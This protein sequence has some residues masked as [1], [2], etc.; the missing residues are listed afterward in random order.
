MA[1]RAETILAAYP[2]GLPASTKTYGQA[3]DALAA[4]IEGWGLEVLRR[5]PI[6]GR[7]S[8]DI[9]VSSKSVAVE[10]CGLHWHNEASPTPR[11]K[12]YHWNKMR[13]AA[14]RGLR[15]ITIFEDEWRERRPQVTG[16]LRSILGAPHARVQARKCEV[17]ELDAKTARVF[18]EDHHIQRLNTSQL[19][20]WGLTETCTGTLV[21]VV[22]LRHHR[23]S[24]DRSKVDL[25]RLCFQTDYQVVGGA[26]RLI[27]HAA[28]WAKSAGYASIVTWSDNRWFTGAVYERLGFNLVRDGGPDYAYVKVDCSRGRIPKE[29]FRKSRTG[30]PPD[31]LEHVRA[32]EEG[33][34]RIW[35]CG[36]KRWELQL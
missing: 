33:Y 28:A 25:T 10:F 15:L 2:H 27:R 23:M 24:K 18:I 11:D 13:A 5:V 9:V 6:D 22:T 30:C 3:E 16:V 8:L 36:H 14:E 4:L 12:T 17:T 29:Q 31:V 32:L 7:K 19:R 34:A 35:D 26:S 21:G 1:K 20:A